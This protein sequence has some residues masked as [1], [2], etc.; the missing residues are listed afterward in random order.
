MLCYSTCFLVEITSV[1]QEELYI[2]IPVPSCFKGKW[3]L[4]VAIMQG[5]QLKFGEIT[6]QVSEYDFSIICHKLGRN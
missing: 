6:Q 5:N 1:A 4:K 2:H 3:E